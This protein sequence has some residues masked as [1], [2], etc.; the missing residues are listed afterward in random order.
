MTIQK[1]QSLGL[2]G[3]ASAT[4]AIILSSSLILYPEPTS[5]NILTALRV[6]SVTTAVPFLLVFAARPLAMLSLSRE[7]GQW[8]Q[9]NRRY[10]WFILTISHLL[11]L[12]QITLY[13]QLGQSCPF[14]VWAIT[15]PLWI[16]M[17]LFSLVEGVNPHLFDRL[18]QGRGNLGIKVLHGLGSGYVWLVF[19]LAFGLGV[20]DKHLLFYNVPALASFLAGAFLC[21]ITWWWRR[22]I[23]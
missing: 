22:A 6:S 11:H 3:V 21:G 20:F 8:A 9:A 16:I 12:Y 4:V 18:Y 5:E 2:G 1:Q 10:L 19:T 14:I 7:L 13:Y 23:A 17:V 15:A